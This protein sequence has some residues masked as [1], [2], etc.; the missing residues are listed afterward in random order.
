M[1][2]KEAGKGDAKKMNTKGWSEDIK[3]NLRELE[4]AL[5]TLVLLRDW[6]MKNLVANDV[7]PKRLPEEVFEYI[8]KLGKALGDINDREVSL[9]SQ[10]SSDPLVKYLSALKLTKEEFYLIKAMDMEI[11]LMGAK[12]FHL[13]DWDDFEFFNYFRYED[14][15]RTSYIN[16]T[17]TQTDKMKVEI[18]FGE[19]PEELE[20]SA[21]RPEQNMFFQKYLPEVYGRFKK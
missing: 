6:L 12:D 15:Q 10:L 8:Q 4:E 18:K 20:L 2:H 16:P 5:Q 1:E 21:L 14:E 7:S 13:S 9:F 19:P 17:L 3:T 11:P